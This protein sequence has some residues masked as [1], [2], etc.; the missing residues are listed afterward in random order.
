[1]RRAA[2]VATLLAATAACSKPVAGESCKTENQEVCADDR[3][4][5]VCVD[6]K[7]EKLTCRGAAG[8]KSSGNDVACANDTFAD[9]EPCDPAQNDYECGPDRVS[10]M[11]CKGKH[12]KLAGKCPG[13]KGCVSQKQ[14]VTCDDSIADVGM[15]CAT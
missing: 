8:C 6:A 13:P 15:P 9:G 2:L 7:W 5:L 1:M 12:W 14:K 11:K 10:V 3:E 4:A